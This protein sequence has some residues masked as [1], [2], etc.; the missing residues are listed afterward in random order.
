[1]EHHVRG[2]ELLLLSWG[3]DMMGSELISDPEP[4]QGWANWPIRLA[5]CNNS[6][7]LLGQINAGESSAKCAAYLH[8]AGNSMIYNGRDLLLEILD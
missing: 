3:W 8:E 4:G 5:K 7:R 6:M 2:A 1:M